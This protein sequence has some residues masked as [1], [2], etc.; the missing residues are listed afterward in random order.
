MPNY[1]LSGSRMGGGGGGGSCCC[2]DSTIDR[3]SAIFFNTL[4]SK[5]L[6]MSQAVEAKIDEIKKNC[7]QPAAAGRG[8]VFASIDTPSMVISVPPEFMEYIKRY[9]PPPKGKFDPIKL[10]IIRAQLGL[11]SNRI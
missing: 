8:F 9:G 11:G 2:E 5:L 10:E 3:N 1:I 7:H 4:A 6:E